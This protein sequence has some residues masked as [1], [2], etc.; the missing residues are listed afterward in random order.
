MS[1]LNLKTIIGLIL[2]YYFMSNY[3]T[4]FNFLK[5]YNEN[6]VFSVGLYLLIQCFLLKLLINVLLFNLFDLSS[7]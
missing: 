1:G 5:K 6:K 4:F 7:K 2:N 3:N